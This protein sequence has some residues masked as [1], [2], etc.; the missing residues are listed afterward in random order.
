[1]SAQARKKRPRRSST[2]E[3]KASTVRLVLEE[4]KAI[5]QV[6][7]QELKDAVAGYWSD[8][9]AGVALDLQAVPDSDLSFDVGAEGTGCAS[10]ARLS[11]KGQ[12]SDLAGKNSGGI[13][14]ELIPGLVLEGANPS[15]SVASG[16]CTLAYQA[17]KRK[18]VSG[19]GSLGLPNGNL[20]WTRKTR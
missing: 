20:E 3:Y 13:T 6:A 12:A 9:N 7:A 4:G 17:G 8:E 2:D 11:L 16:S 5:P 1:M 15:F 18:G 19:L 14:G 10:M